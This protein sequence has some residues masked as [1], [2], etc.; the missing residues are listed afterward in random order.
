MADVIYL[1]FSKAFDKV[2]HRRLMRLLMHHGIS[3]YI[4]R[5]IGFW[6]TK[7]RQRVVLNGA[8]SDWKDVTSGVPQGSVL[9]P[10]LFLIY[11]NLIDD[12]LSTRKGGFISKFADDTK[13]A[14]V[15]DTQED[16]MELQTEL[17]NLTQWSHNCTMNFNED[18]CK[19]THFGRKNPHAD[20]LNIKHERFNTQ[21]DIIFENFE[22]HEAPRQF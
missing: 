5:W 1:D 14:R 22:C 12:C 4:H 19:V 17:D 10:S 6:L 3:G 13:L 15:I 18:K 8:K 2:G 9:G 7:R 21:Y 16:S 11:V 20:R